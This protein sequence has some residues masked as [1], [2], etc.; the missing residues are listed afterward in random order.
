M[1]K[2][3]S[4]LLLA[5]LFIA[6]HSNAQN[7]QKIPGKRHVSSSKKS[8]EKCGFSL[9]MEKAKA[10]GFNEALYEQKMA[11]LIAQRRASLGTAKP[12]SIYTVP[13]IFHV[14]YSGTNEPVPGIGANLDKA[15][16]DAQITQLNNDFANLSG[17]VYGVAQDMGIRFIPARVDPNGNLLCEPGI[18]RINWETRSGWL[19]PSTILTPTDL[20]N[21]YNNIV[22]PQSIWDPYRYVNV[23][24]GDFSSSGLLGYSTFPANSTLSGLDNTETDLTAGVIVLSGS[25]GSVTT[26]GDAFPYDLGKTA[27]HELGHFF[28]LRH[29]WGDGTCATDYCN[30]TPPQDDA[31]AGCPATGTLNNCVPSGPKMF[32]N[33]MDYTDDACMNTFTFNQSERCQTVMINSLRRISLAT[34]NAGISPIPNRISFKTGATTVA[35]TGTTG[36]CP[37]YKDVSVI[38]AVDNAATGPATVSLTKS[39]TATDNADYIITPASVSYTNGDNAE[40]TFTV[41]IYD[42]PTVE[43][44]ESITLGINITGTGV[45]TSALCA[46]SNQLTIT[47]TDDDYN[48]DINNTNPT[49]T[50]LTQNFG[51][52][53]GS[54]QVPAG[55]TVS[56]SGST[57]NKWVGNNAGA[58]TYGFTGNT[59][60]IS[61]GNATAVSNGTAAMSY[62]ITTTTDA[63]VT[64]PSVTPTNLKNITLSFNFVSNGEIDQ[65]VIYDLGVVYYSIDGGTNYTILTDPAGNFYLFQGVTT[66]SA[67]NVVMPASIITAPNLK[68]LFRWLSDNTGGSQPPF[69][70]DDVVLTG[71]SLTVENQ[72]S[73][74]GTVYVA[75]NTAPSYIYSSADGQLISRIDNLSANIGCLTGTITSAGTGQ[76]AVTTNTGAYFRSDKVVQL[77]PAS[78]NSTATYQ[79]T[80]Y[81]TTAELATW[82]ASVSTLKLLKVKDGTSLASVLNGSNAQVFNTTVDDQRATKGY[83]A[84]TANVTGGFS[85][86]M[87]ASPTITIPVTLI[88]FQARAAVKNIVLDWSTA[89]EQNNKG[90]VIERSI[91]GTV[92]EKIGWVD[93]KI[94]SSQVSRYVYTDNFVQPNVLYY[95]RL[96]QTDIDGFEKLSVTRQAKIKGTDISI[97]VNPN[98]AKD[99][100]RVFVSGTSGTTDI[101]LVNAAGQLVRKWKQVNASSAPATLDISRLA[102][103]MYMLQVF[104]AQ[105]TTV[106]KLIIK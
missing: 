33:Y 19:D 104:T 84:F 86:F 85:Q 46:S 54:N 28:G 58:A 81:Y 75:A 62:T 21:H 20:I 6:F 100:L 92:F 40:K 73:N 71:Q 103:G 66:K 30:D 16:V 4:T 98:P 42:D 105:S 1:R 49:T 50:L 25:V 7:L 57:T 39:G 41:R 3:Y 31:T 23:W 12:T 87:L 65:G 48:V 5:G 35:E 74:T 70:I 17:S 43:G 67:L 91:D 47:I 44:T 78:A 95:Y 80:L 18:E 102:A 106:E 61:N 99:Q 56:N 88:D 11:E 26:P 55:W 15:L 45:Q 63:R 27:T 37:R 32:E 13:V 22:K 51:T 60:H 76:T 97:S 79:L 14:I 89:T 68:F 93:G 36:T 101:N 52:T 8:S 90:F 10:A 2:I 77:T 34:S 72:L 82:G 38:I 83:A 69:A 96:R 29:I 94:N 9:M 59:L 53:T 64:T 24:L